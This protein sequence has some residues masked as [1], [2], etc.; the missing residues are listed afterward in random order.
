MNGAESLLR[1]LVEPGV[2][3]CFVNP[4]LR[5]CILSQPSIESPA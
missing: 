3:V 4:A 5:K 2:E 1:T